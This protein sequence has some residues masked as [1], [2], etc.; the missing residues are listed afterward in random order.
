[1]PPPSPKSA[2]TGFVR[3]RWAR[4]VLAGGTIDRSYESC[5]VS[6]LRAWVRAGDVW[7]AGSRQYRSIA[8]RLIS[9]E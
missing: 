9:A 1:M 6:E 5:V 4:Y 8:E 7:V 3:Q 2:P